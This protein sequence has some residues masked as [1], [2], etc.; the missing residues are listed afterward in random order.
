MYVI[1]NNSCHL[2]VSQSNMCGLVFTHNAP[3][4]TKRSINI[5]IKIQST[6]CNAKFF[7]CTIHFRL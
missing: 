7:E 6:L 3:L 5:M 1:W 4:G 2:K